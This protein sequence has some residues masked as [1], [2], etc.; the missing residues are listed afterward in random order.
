MH[1]LDIT[2]QGHWNISRMECKEA[3]AGD[4]TARVRIGIYPEWNVKSRKRE[5]SG[6]YANWN[7]S[8]ME[9]KVLYFTLL[10]S[11]AFLLEYIQNGM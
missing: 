8:R 3:L 1:L 9:C 10:N 2:P 5:T 11:S 7:I 6:R 4:K